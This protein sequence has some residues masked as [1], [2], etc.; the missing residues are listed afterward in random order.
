M[1][2]SRNVNLNKKFK[3]W[4]NPTPSHS[5][6]RQQNLVEIAKKRSKFKRNSI[7]KKKESKCNQREVKA[8]L[9]NVLSSGMQPANCFTLNYENLLKTK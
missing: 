8:V 3:S 1:S 5:L 7:E 6:Y 2:E 9:R 4:N